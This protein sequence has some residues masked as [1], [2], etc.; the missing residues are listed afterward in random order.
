MSSAPAVPRKV[1]CPVCAKLIDWV[2]EHR[3]RPF[4]SKRCKMVDLGAWA[5]EE[6]RI[7]EQEQPL[8][9]SDA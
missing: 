5:A 4:C 9:D 3:Y 6:Y 1:N 8:K 2:P 7:P